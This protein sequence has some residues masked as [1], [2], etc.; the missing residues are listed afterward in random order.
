MKKVIFVFV[1]LCSLFAF[2]CN[3]GKPAYS[4][5]QVDSK[6]RG[7]GQSANANANQPATPA[8]DPIAQAEAE[9]AAASGQPANPQ[10]KKDIPAPSFLNGAD[11]KDLPKYKR[12]QVMNAQ[13]GPINGIN[14]ALF[15]LSTP[16]SVEK[17]ST[18]YDSAIK[19][20][21]W[22]VASNL[23]DPESV[24]YTLTKGTR[25]EAMVRIKRDNQSGI[26][27]ITLSRAEVPE[28]QTV[29]TPPLPKAPQPVPQ[30]K[31]KN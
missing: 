30:D 4:D 23:K 7:E 27:V 13:V 29:T 6:T 22:S 11:I 12:S 25:D 24:E 20:N 28:G 3:F 16:D 15:L 9:A 14:S 17:V 19:S 10:D 1:I 21:G 31:K 26:T 5:V 8:V 18:F 2:G